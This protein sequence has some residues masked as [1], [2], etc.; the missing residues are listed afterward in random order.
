[1]KA[2]NKIMKTI[3]TS[4]SRPLRRALCTLLLCIAALW[5]MPRSAHAQVEVG[6]FDS[7]RGGFESLAPGEDSTL[8]NDIAAAF[9]G[10]TFSFSNTLTPSFLNGLN[11][12]I[13]GVATTDSSAITPLTSS[14][15]TALQNFVL[16][17]GTALIFTDNSTF[18]PNAP[19]ANASLLTPFGLTATGTLVGGVNA[20]IL[21]PSGPLTGPF[22]P[23][24]E[25][26]T[27][28]P[29]YFN[30]TGAGTVLA[31]FAPG[32]AAID[33]FA[34]GTLGPHSGAAVFF[35]DSDAMVAGDAL[36]TTNLNLI[37]NAFATNQLTP[38]P[39]PSTWSM[40]AV[41]GAALLGIM[42]RKKQRIA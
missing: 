41:G 9:P 4:N 30:G 39:E 8:A 31:Q 35:S 3:T 37:L 21:N 20:P 32:E 6:G 1:M 13:L 2:E 40:I 34:P 36:T 7:T 10:T 5:A 24:T 28:F 17:G 18:D 16:D 33:Y 14:E 27:N 38:V 11:V 29:G 12:V 26:A 25:F 19:A 22:T 15:Q 42:L 23:V